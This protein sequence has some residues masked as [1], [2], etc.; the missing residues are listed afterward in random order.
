MQ[1][2]ALLAQSHPWNMVHRLQGNTHATDIMPL[3]EENLPFCKSFDGELCFTRM[4]H[5]RQLRDRT[6]CSLAMGV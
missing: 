3:R 2:R 5:D 6:Q 4:L 1:T